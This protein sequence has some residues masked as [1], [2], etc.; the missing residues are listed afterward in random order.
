ALIWEHIED[1]PGKKCPNPRVILPKKLIPDVI[2][3]PVIVDVRSF[4]IRTPPCTKDNPSYGIVGIAQVLPPALAWL[5]RLASPRGHANPS[6]A[7]NIKAL[8]SEGVGSFW[9]FATGKRVRYANLLLEQFK[10]FTDTL[11]LL[12]PNQYIGAYK[13][14]FMPEWIIREYLA[15]RGNAKIKPDQL[16]PSKCSLLGYSLEHIKFEGIY[17]PKSLLQ[18]NLQPDVGDEAFEVGSEM[19]YEFFKEEIA[20]FMTEDLCPLGKKIIE[21]FLDKGTVQD[22][23]RVFSF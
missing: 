1:S 6:I 18:V 17:L 21:C 20:N 9:P 3:D 23:E 4:G 5:W 14:G 22:Y 16:T 19:L 13:V 2:N 10:T 11:Y 7:G 12:I 8:S 15:K